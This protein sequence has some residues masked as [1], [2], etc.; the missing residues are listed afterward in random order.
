MRF[1]GLKGPC[2]NCAGMIEIPKA[3]VDIQDA[4]KTKGENRIL[5]RPIERLGLDFEPLHV[6]YSILGIVGVLLLTFL[7]GSIPMYDVVRSLIGILGL[8][9]VAF[10]LTLFGYHILRDSEQIFAFF[11]TELYHRVCITAAGYV[12]LWIV[13]E[14]FLTVIR[15]NAIISCFYIAVFAVFTSLLSCWFLELRN[16]DAFLHF[17]VFGISVILL[18]FVLGLGWLWQSSE[19]IRHSTAPLPPLLPGM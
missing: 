3:S 5:T 7:I 1:A 9:L 8:C 15:A 18:R 13:M 12:I 19:L 6:K 16:R 2:P 11:G 10:P 4:D 17:C 14:F